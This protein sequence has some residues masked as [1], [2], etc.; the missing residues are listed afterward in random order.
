VSVEETHRSTKKTIAEFTD[1]I[2]VEDGLFNSR[3]AHFV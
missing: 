2:R 1:W 3:T